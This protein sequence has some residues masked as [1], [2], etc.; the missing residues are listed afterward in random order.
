MVEYRFLKYLLMILRI[1]S[2]SIMMSLWF[3]GECGGC[4]LPCGGLNVFLGNESSQLETEMAE[5]ALVSE[6]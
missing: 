1:S 6:E 4:L 3:L 5:E 2:V